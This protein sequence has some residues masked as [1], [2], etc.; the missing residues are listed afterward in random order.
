MFIKK[1]L[2]LCIVFL[3]FLC[4]LL[5]AMSFHFAELAKLTKNPE[6]GYNAANVAEHYDT[7]L[8]LAIP[9]HGDFSSKGLTA[10]T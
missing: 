9:K 5:D 10:S 3:S 8:L 4:P 2:T 1:I 6:L 7:A